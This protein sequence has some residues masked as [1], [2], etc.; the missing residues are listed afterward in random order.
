MT[1]ELDPER[2]ARRLAALAASYQ[3]ETVGEGRARLRIDAMAPESFATA[4]ERRLEELRA[5][6]ELTRY[7]IAN[8]PAKP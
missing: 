7:L 8:M 5:L 3:P 4:V 6:D 2:V 1:R